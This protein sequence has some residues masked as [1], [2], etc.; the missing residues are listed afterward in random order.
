MTL[1]LIREKFVI[2][3]KAFNIVIPLYSINNRF[4]VFKSF[5]PLKHHFY[6]RMKVFY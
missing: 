6:D 2:N 1:K 3:V 4:Q 5:F